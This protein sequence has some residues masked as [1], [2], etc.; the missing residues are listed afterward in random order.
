ML[1]MGGRTALTQQSSEAPFGTRAKGEASDGAKGPKVDVS[2]P[3]KP[4]FGMEKREKH[5]RTSAAS[6]AEEG[7][8]IPGYLG[9]DLG[10]S[11]SLG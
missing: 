6:L 1:G 7:K 9:W 5:S 8:D 3:Q 4:E 10:K 2:K 11:Q